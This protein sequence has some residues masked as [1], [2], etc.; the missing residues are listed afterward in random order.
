[1]NKLTKAAIAGAAGIALL[2]GGA[3][4]LAL[5]NASDTVSAGAVNT[6]TLTLTA[7]AGSW[8]TAP[9]KWVPGDS[10]EYTANVVVTAVGE[11]IMGTLSVDP[12]SITG[13]AGLIA[14]LDISLTVTGTLPGGVSSNGDGTYN[15]ANPGTYSLP[16][17]VT[18]AFDS[19][20]DNSTQGKSVNL[21]SLAFRVDQHL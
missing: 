8:N 7:T 6:G 19:T 13:D 4:S 18:V 9:A 15:I 1:M 17:K 3:G 20:S 21:T 11:H 10:Y 14:D 5:W 2:L 12:A 16:V